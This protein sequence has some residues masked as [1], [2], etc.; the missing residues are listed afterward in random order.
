MTS[1]VPILFTVT[2][3]WWGVGDPALSGT[4]STPSLEP[5]S[6]LALFS[7]RLPKGFTAYC[8]N[9]T[10]ADNVDCVQTV[11]LL[12]QPDG[13]TWVLGYGGYST[14][15]M[16]Y[17]AS[18]SEVQT[19]LAALTSIGTGNVTVAQGADQYTFVVTFVGTL[20]NQ[21][22]LAMTWDDSKLTSSVGNTVAI[23]VEITTPGSTQR[24]AD[25]ALSIPARQGRI[26][27]G[28]LSSI[29][30]SDSVGVELVA[31]DPALNL[32]DQNIPTLIYDV[33]FSQV[34]L[35]EGIQGKLANFA[36]AAP[37]DATPVNLTDPEFPRL[38]WQ[39]P[40]S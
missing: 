1:P 4:T 9:F 19:A 32:I 7:P 10:V 14:T 35:V 37:A 34:T 16:P 27:A 21:P 39:P 11:T 2:G 33:T 5:T 12:G 31:N 26:W 28:Q 8:S 29:D 20:A 15:A 22:I 23:T 18:A 3:D 25:T 36:F 6:G 17:N 30:V 38:T 24:S 40:I 13:G